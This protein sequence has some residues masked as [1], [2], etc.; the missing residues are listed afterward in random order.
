MIG[1][2]AVAFWV[3]FH[4]LD[5]FIGVNPKGLTYTTII[6]IKRRTFAYIREHGRAPQKLEQ[7]PTLTG[8]DNSISDGWENPIRYSVDTSGVVTVESFGSDG[9]PGGTGYAEDIIVSFP[10]KDTNGNWLQK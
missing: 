1:F 8:Y 3:A 4:V 6:V 5:D 9:K 2:I 10:T 7:L